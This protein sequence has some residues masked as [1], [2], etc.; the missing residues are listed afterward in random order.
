MTGVVVHDA[1][2]RD[3]Q[4]AVGHRLSAIEMRVYAAAASA[5]GVPVIEVG[6]GNGLGAS[7]LQLGL[8]TETDEAMIAAARE[9]LM[10]GTR[11]GVFAI[12]G[13]AT[14]D[15]L[16]AA[17]AAG[18]EVVRIGVHCTEVSLAR[19]H[20]ETAASEGVQAE[21]VLMMSH[22]GTPEQL[23]AQ[24]LEAVERGAAAVGVMDSAGA[25]LPDDVT[26]RIC[27]IV[28]AVSVPVGFHAHDNLSLAIANSLAA[29]QA[30]ARSVDACARGFGAGAGN[31][32]LE[33]LVPVLERHSF[34]TGIDLYSILEVAE[35]ADQTFVRRTPSP[36]SQ[37]IVGGLAGVFSGFARHVETWSRD[38]QVDPRDVIFELGRRQVVAGQEDAIPAAI[39]AVEARKEE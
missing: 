36:D 27:A 15:D 30:G 37:T 3:G 18:A 34:T 32:R 35:L 21:C 31:A 4:H 17:T 19:N 25:L 8:A 22:M 2:L 6:H 28:A 39:E 7:S 16:R 13:W 38:R 20:L 9:A 24:A 12:P 10:P 23:A 26:Q 11:L 33:V 1:T 5:A 29:V 14:R